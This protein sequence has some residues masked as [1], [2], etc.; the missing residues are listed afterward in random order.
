MKH[1]RILLD[2][3]KVNFEH[4]SKLLE[5]IKEYGIL[6]GFGFSYEKGNEKEIKK[7]F[8]RYLLGI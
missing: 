4:V 6:S 3:K 2:L 5:E 7:L 1:L 8:D